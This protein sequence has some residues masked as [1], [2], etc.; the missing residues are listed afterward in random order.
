M[1]A[2]KGFFLPI[3][4]ALA[5][6]VA[7]AAEVPDAS[8]LLERAIEFHGGREALA[9]LP[10]VKAV[11]IYEPGGWLAGRTL[12]AVVY[13]KADGSRRVEVDFEFGGRKGTWV[14]I[15]DGATCKRRS[16][17]TW[18]DIPV[19]QNRERAAHR[20][21]I[22]LEVLGRS[23]EVAGEGNEAGSA[24]WLVTFPDGRDRAV[25][26]LAKQDGHVVA[27]EYPGTSAQGM[28][29]E[30][31]VR[32]KLVFRAFRETGGVMLPTDIEVLEDGSF[33]ERWRFERLE[34]I[35]DWDDEWLRIPDPRRRFIPSEEQAT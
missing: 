27:I 10:D 35:R 6:G 33:N 4:A 1:S 26:S 30:K 14:E 19:D 12:D 18:D 5:L 24:V 21:P 13:D 3:V 20:L 8:A 11:G 15:Y 7:P 23:P 34:T 28:G 22:L 17:G 31:E 16:R 9:S 25:L 32:R 2:R 29:T